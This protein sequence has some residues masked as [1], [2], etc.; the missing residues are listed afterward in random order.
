MTELEINALKNCIEGMAIDAEDHGQDAFNIRLSVQDAF[1]ICRWQPK[2]EIAGVR[3]GILRD[4]MDCVCH[5]RQTRYGGPERSFQ[6]IARLWNTYIEGKG[7]NFLNAMD[8]A[9]MMALMKIARIATGAN[10]RDNW[11]DLAGYAACGGEIES[12]IEQD[13][14]ND[15]SLS[16]AAAGKGTGEN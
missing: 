3:E 9:A 8:V 16:E 4:A 6:T 10:H 13:A 11:V 15:V 1:E 5:D 2:S 12:E 14:K 7:S